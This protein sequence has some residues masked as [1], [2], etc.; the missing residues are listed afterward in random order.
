MTES[1]QKRPTTTSSAFLSADIVR[2][3]NGARARAGASEEY[4]EGKKVT[5]VILTWNGLAYTK[6]CLETLRGRTAF[7][8]YEVVVVDN[9]STDG[10]VEYLRSLP[11]VR[12]FEN[13]VNLGFVKGNN[14]AFAKCGGESDFVL[15]NNDTEIIQPEW[16]SRLQGT[17]Y[18]APEVGIV[19]ARLRRPE[20]MLQHA[21]TYMPLETFWGQQ[22]GAGE[23]DINQFNADA[24][25][26]G[27]V[28]ACT[29][30][31]R[32]VYERVG[33]LDEDYFSYFEDSDYCLKAQS[34]G[35]KVFCCGRATVGR[36]SQ[37][38]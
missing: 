5:I 31:K 34:H 22:I 18:S 10:T 24:E 38:A 14:R 36:L 11:W 1:G 12:L 27:V 20:G 37:G 4:R 9:G 6:R 21:G 3:R 15:L 19:G 32:E 26:E 35:F 28:F 16:L 30:I 23:R 17:A 29:Y 7:P 33:P 25:V 2:R 8:D 13:R